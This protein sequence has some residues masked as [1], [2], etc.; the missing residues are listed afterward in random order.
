[1]KTKLIQKSTSTTEL[2]WDNVKGLL[3]EESLKRRNQREA[4][5]DSK[6]DDRS[7]LKNVQCF[8]CKHFG[9]IARN[10]RVKNYHTSSA[11]VAE[12]GDDEV[13]DSKAGDERGG[14]ALISSATQDTNAWFI[15]S[16]ATK[17]MSN[18]RSLFKDYLEYKKPTKIYLGDDTIVL[19]FGEGKVD[20]TSCMNSKIVLNLH[21]VLYAP[22]LTKNLLSVPAM[23][24]MGAEVLFNKGNC[25]VKKNGK[26]YVIGNLAGSKLYKMNTISESEEIAVPEIT[27]EGD[28]EPV[29]AQAVPNEE[30]SKGRT[31]EE[32]FMEEVKS[33]RPV[34]ERR[35]PLRFE[36]E[37]CLAS[38]NARRDD[39]FVGRGRIAKRKKKRTSVTDYTKLQECLHKATQDCGRQ[40]TKEKWA[41]VAKWYYGTDK[42]SCSKIRGL[43][44]RCR[45]HSPTITD[46]DLHAEDVMTGP[47]ASGIHGSQKDR[48]SLTSSSDKTTEITNEMSP[49]P[50]N[51]LEADSTMNESTPGC[52]KGTNRVEN[53]DM[54]FDNCSGTQEDKELET[55]EETMASG[56]N[57][58]T[59]NK[60]I[61][62]E[63]SKTP[64]VAPEYINQ[65]VSSI[66]AKIA[67]E[68]ANKCLFPRIESV[69]QKTSIDDRPERRSIDS[70]YAEAESSN[71]EQVNERGKYQ[72][73]GISGDTINMLSSSNIP[74][75]GKF[76]APLPGNVSHKLEPSWQE[77]LGENR[78]TGEWTNHFAKIIAQYNPYCTLVFKGNFVSRLN[79]RKRTCPLVKGYAVCAHKPECSCEAHFS[80]RKENRNILLLEFK[81]SICHDLAIRK[82]RRISGME[83]A[84]RTAV[85]E[86]DINLPPSDVYRNDLK[87]ISSDV[88]A[89]GNR[90]NAGASKRV[91]QQIK[92]EARKKHSDQ[93]LLHNLL[94]ELQ[95]KIKSEDQATSKKLR[96]FQRRMHGYIQGMQ[97]V[98]DLR[99]VLLHESTIRL[100]HGVA[101]QDIL[102][103][104]ATGS[105]VQK[106]VSYKRILYYTLCVRHPFGKT[107]PLPI[108]EFLSSAHTT[109]A[110]GQC[111]LS[112]KEKEKEIFN[113]RISQPALIL[114]DNSL[115]MITACLIVFN[116]E[117]MKTYI[118]RTLR[119][120]QGKATAADLHLTILHICYSHSMK[121]N[122]TMIHKL[123]KRRLD[124]T[125]AYVSNFLM[126]FFARLIEC[127][128]LDELT[129]LVKLG[130]VLL[131]SRFLT[132]NAIDALKELE[133]N[134]SQYPFITTSVEDIQ[135]DED[136]P[137]GTTGE[138]HELHDAESA[139]WAESEETEKSLAESK[140]STLS[141][142]WAK[143]LDKLKRQIT[144]PLDI[145]ISTAL[146]VNRLYSPRYM[147]Y[148][149]KSKLPTATLWTNLCLGDLTRFNAEE[150]K[151]KKVSFFIARNTDVQ[152]KTSGQ[153]EGLFS[154]MKRNVCL[155]KIPVDQFVRRLWDLRNGLSRQFVDG[156][157]EGMKGNSKGPLKQKLLQSIANQLDSN[158][159][160]DDSTISPQQQ[161]TVKEMWNKATP[162]KKTADGD[163]YYRPGQRHVTFSPKV[164]D[165]SG[166]AT[167]H[168]F[169]KDKIAFNKFRDSVWDRVC[170]DS[171]TVMECMDTVRRH[172]KSLSAEEQRKFVDKKESKKA[173]KSTCCCG[174]TW[175]DQRTPMVQCDL[176]KIWYHVACQDVNLAY[177]QIA[178]FYHCKECVI[179]NFMPF[180][181]FL[182]LNSDQLMLHSSDSIKEQYEKWNALS[183]SQQQG[184]NA[185]PFTEILARVFVKKE[186]YSTRGIEN[187]HMTTCWMNAVLQII[188]GSAIYDLLPFTSSELSTLLSGVH[189]QL[190]NKENILPLPLS[191][192]MYRMC[193]VVGYPISTNNQYDSLEFLGYFINTLKVSVAPG[194]MEQFISPKVA[195]LLICR[196]CPTIRGETYQQN[197]FQVHVPDTTES[198]E[199]SSLI[200]DTAAC[201]YSLESQGPGCACGKESTVQEKEDNT[202]ET[203]S[204][205]KQGMY[206][207]V[208]FLLDAPTVLVVETN[209]VAEPIAVGRLKKTPVIVNES[210]DL[211][212]SARRETE[213]LSYRLV[214]AT[215]LLARNQ[216]SGHYVSTIFDQSGKA[217]TYDD[218]CVIKTSTKSK[219]CSTV[220]RKSTYLLFYVQNR[221][222]EREETQKAGKNRPWALEWKEK[223][224]VINIW[225]GRDENCDKC[226]AVISKYD[227]MTLS[228][229]NWVNEVCIQECITTFCNE[230][231]EIHITSTSTYLFTSLQDGRKTQEIFNIMS[232]ANW[233][234]K[235]LILVPIHHRTPSG[236]NLHWSIAGIYPKCKVVIHCD[237]LHVQRAAVFSILLSVVKRWCA[238][239]KY[240]FSVKE[241]HLISSNEIPKQVNGYDCG[242]HACLNAYC[243]IRRKLWIP[244]PE[245]LIDVRIWLAFRLLSTSA[246]PTTGNKRLVA[247]LPIETALVQDDEIDKQFPQVY[248]RN[249]ENA[250]DCIRRLV[251]ECSNIKSEIAYFETMEDNNSEDRIAEDSTV[252]S[253]DEKSEPDSQSLPD[254]DP[255]AL[256][257][258]QNKE[259][260]M[261]Q[262]RLSRKNFQKG[263]LISERIAAVLTSKSM[264]LDTAVNEY[265]ILR[266]TYGEERLEAMAE[267][268]TKMFTYYKM[269]SDKLFDY[270][271]IQMEHL[272]ERFSLARGHFFSLVVLPELLTQFE[273]EKNECPYKAAVKYLYNDMDCTTTVFHR[274]LL[275]KDRK[276]TL[277]WPATSMHTQDS[278][279]IQ[280]VDDDIKNDFSEV[281]CMLVEQRSLHK[282]TIEKS[283]AVKDDDELVGD[284]VITEIDQSLPGQQVYHAIMQ[285]D[286]KEK[287]DNKKSWMRMTNL[288]EDCLKRAEK[289]QFASIA[290]EA[291][292]IR[293]SL[294]NPASKKTATTILEAVWKFCH[295]R[296]SGP[297]SLKIFRIVTSNKLLQA[298]LKSEMKTISKK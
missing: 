83:R 287:Q 262:I 102:Y 43:Y 224:Q 230:V 120:V 57:L 168:E 106:L 151:K 87:N 97:T 86:R 31:Y 182:A 103:F 278:F 39:K 178:T 15:D 155:L 229:R 123:A 246:A 37:E 271:G 79:S 200:W 124:A 165:F 135:I 40:S 212:V 156:L 176:C 239:H 63:L 94:A 19:A 122:K 217:V 100:Y 160:D 245:E 244:A 58:G 72:S 113:N 54:V 35:P 78:L 288:V 95:R 27:N 109:E 118:D 161:K 116:N 291:F 208:S 76:K 88:F 30:R 216:F 192:E 126:H 29:G 205:K 157:W 195:N 92:H 191:R 206:Y 188:C 276:A 251:H 71:V 8:K 147:E 162:K 125:T 114:V 134:I 138:R 257:F 14:M 166:K 177:A 158:A 101:S 187:P 186:V 34:R 104:D 74:A 296:A 197:Y 24:L 11:N 270:G 232:D 282:N 6:G 60:Q 142:Y 33:L 121:W 44:D 32:S 207:Y 173:E 174:L 132:N 201:Q 265:T 77:F 281:K 28:K 59:I 241:W 297:T 50:E 9:H 181:R 235:D 255:F 111:L 17:H 209:R 20:L 163:G 267:Y 243:L 139:V 81:G 140:G 46:T 154:T 236:E 133:D 260:V 2:D 226:S 218:T 38:S 259:S 65:Y 159:I 258:L 53:S 55:A 275:L 82:A 247:L 227:I 193:E 215:N 93:S 26:E 16:A 279:F 172:W 213:P 269:P 12:G 108:L 175:E 221:C 131:M 298:T 263:K 249:G 49:A 153:I 64:S 169:V 5:Q 237:S 199:L 115:A 47:N 67:V 80:I 167:S 280:V 62:Y 149:M 89:A 68:V 119:I 222:F 180:I 171:P 290:F 272:P 238:E 261:E 185:I 228:G 130:M 202:K 150:Y 18:D 148:L 91:M 274:N 13:E 198:L 42:V 145:K 41:C 253:M 295:L 234:K 223:Q 25:I 184:I 183:L 110:I 179:G 293:Q 143:E 84:K 73:I 85:F 214:G 45:L 96:H 189:Q 170:V 203:D 284:V 69:P 75:D 164:L 196:S 7:D 10:C 220:F 190:S 4:G 283:T 252:G 21:K 210:I 225:L 266:K 277:L 285:N 136:N 52:S 66:C 233:L 98:P 117:S 268:V 3:I 286:F 129:R 242:A 56:V 289:K 36:D 144:K 127:R 204:T 51:K 1:M 152:N 294:R 264:F 137:E 273:M 256:S 23:T 61:V 128:R 240:T 292:P 248:L 194:V 146:P 231:D 48:N 254:D 105:V 211:C 112:L 250:F 90:D 141:Q 22:A 70:T 99:V 219:L 107:P